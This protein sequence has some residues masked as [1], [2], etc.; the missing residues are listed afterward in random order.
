MLVPLTHSLTPLPPLTVILLTLSL[1]SPSLLSQVKDLSGNLAS[2]M[3]RFVV[4]VC[5]NGEHICEGMTTDDGRPQCSYNGACGVTV[6][7]TAVT[8]APPR[9]YQQHFCGLPGIRFIYL[10]TAARQLFIPDDAVTRIPWI[11]GMECKA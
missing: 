6:T 1:T 10:P 11:A 5:P 8:V 3:Y 2:T 9:E 4:V 7:A